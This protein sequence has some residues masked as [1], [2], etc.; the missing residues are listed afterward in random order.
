[1]DLVRDN[2]KVV[3]MA[4]LLDIVAVLMLVAEKVGE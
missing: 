1:M 2:C 4:H 3:K